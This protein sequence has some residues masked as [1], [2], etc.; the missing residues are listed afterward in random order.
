MTNAHSAHRSATLKA[1]SALAVALTVRLAA[2]SASARA[3]HVDPREFQAQGYQFVDQ[4]GHGAWRHSNGGEILGGFAGPDD[5][6][7]VYTGEVRSR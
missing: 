7:N 5:L 4:Q 2:N 3:R 1:V 6:V